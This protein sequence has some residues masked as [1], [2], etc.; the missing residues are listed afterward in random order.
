MKVKEPAAT[1]YTPSMVNALQ[2]SIVNRVSQWL[3]PCN[4]VS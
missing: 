1:Y 2:R 4:A 3:M